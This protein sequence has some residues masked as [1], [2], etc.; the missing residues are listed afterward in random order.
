MPE[1]KTGLARSFSS[2]LIAKA[3]EGK[4][5]IISGGFEDEMETQTSDANIDVS[6]FRA[7][8]EEED[9]LPQF[10]CQTQNNSGSSETLMYCFFY[11]HVLPV[12]AWENILW[13]LSGTSI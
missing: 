6:V 2:N 12:Y 8:H 4:I 7:S 9:N 1:N 10:T 11:K 5:I 13:M 3:P